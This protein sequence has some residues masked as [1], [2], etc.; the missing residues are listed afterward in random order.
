MHFDLNFA[1]L[2]S[3]EIVD[4]GRETQLQVTKNYSEGYSR[5]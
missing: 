1:N 5:G 4:R 3:L 2:Q